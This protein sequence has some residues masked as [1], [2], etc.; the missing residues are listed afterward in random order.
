MDPCECQVSNYTGITANVPE[1]KTSA[2]ACDCFYSIAAHVKHLIPYGLPATMAVPGDYNGAEG[3][4]LPCDRRAVTLPLWSV[5]MPMETKPLTAG[6]E[7]YST[8]IVYGA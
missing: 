7:K 2:K 1:V 3:F 5:V 6:I 8:G 4:L